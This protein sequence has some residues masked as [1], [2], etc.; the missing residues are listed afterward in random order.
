MR[1]I[2]A[3]FS[4]LFNDRKDSHFVPIIV[5]FFGHGFHVKMVDFV[6]DFQVSGQQV[7]EQRNWPTFES[8]GKDRVVGVSASFASDVPCL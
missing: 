5:V 1:H 6:D 4:V 2:N 3:F 8:L 7:L